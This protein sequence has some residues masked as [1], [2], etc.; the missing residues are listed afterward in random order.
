MVLAMGV[1]AGCS[2]NDVQVY[3]VAKES[4]PVPPT[5]MPAGHPD[6][7]DAAAPALKYKTPMGWQ[8]VAPGEMRA[9]SLRVA[10]QNGK[11]ADVSVIPLPGLAGGDLGNVNRWRGQVGLPE[12]SQE[13]LTKVVQPVQMEG[14]AAQLYDQAGANPGSGDKTRIL[15]AILRRDG[16]AWFFKMTGDDALVAQQKSNF[17]EFLQSVTFPA[18]TAQSGLPPS[19]PPIGG[20]AELPPSHPPIGGAS[21]MG[22]SA[23]AASSGQD[24]PG[25]QVP[26]GW[27]ETPGGQFLVAKFLI[28][29]TGVAQ[30]NVNVSMSAGDGGGLL[31]N[32][33]RWRGQLGLTPVTEA[34]LAKQVQPL[35]VSVPDSKAMLAEMAGTDSRTGQKTR[36]LAAIVPQGQQTW[37]YKLMGN[38]QVVEQQKEA[39]T[40]FVQAVKYP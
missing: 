36:L 30:A 11:Q 15:A 38:E 40:K 21:A 26:A 17:V 20:G 1:L 16:V 32:F 28:P 31:A 27:Q 4:P 8:E 19:H 37:F 7:T 6:T 34:D 33:N 35:V 22:S 13:E 9:A 14:Q 2:R 23:P 25:W 5:A 39:F 10:G 29:G 12:I 18:A 24:K 3:K